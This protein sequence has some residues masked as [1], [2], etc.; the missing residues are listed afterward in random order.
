MAAAASCCCRR[1]ETVEEEE[2]GR[3]KATGRHEQGS[4]FGDDDDDGDDD[5]DAI[6]VVLSR[7]GARERGKDALVV[8]LRSGGALIRIIMASSREKDLIGEFEKAKKL[9]MNSEEKKQEGKKKA[10]HC[11]STSS[12]SPLFSSIPFALPS[13]REKEK[14]ARN[15]RLRVRPRGLARHPRR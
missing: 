9:V 1:A 15:G 13:P 5:N 12:A 7:L 6:V 3:P 8:A 11:F 10:N 2:V 4:S 14:K